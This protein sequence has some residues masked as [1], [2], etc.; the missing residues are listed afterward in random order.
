MVSCRDGFGRLRQD[1]VR[2]SIILAMLMTAYALPATGAQE[3]EAA[4]YDH[5]MSM[6]ER[7]PEAAFDEAIAWRDLGGGAPARHCAAAALLLLGY[8]QESATRFEELAQDPLLD[9]A[10]KP[11]ILCQAAEGWLGEGNTERAY[12]ALTS[13][14]KLQD[15]NPDLWLDRGIVLAEMGL[16]DEAVDDLSRA[17]VLDPGDPAGWLLRGSAYRLMEDYDAADT[18]IAEALRL[19]PS[20]LGAYL[21]RGNLHR[22]QGNDEAARKDWMI[23]IQRDPGSDLAETAR[24]NLERMDV[25]ST[26]P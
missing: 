3:S 1:M 23:I 8:F 7:N 19:D 2:T 15:S 22:L 6:I 14:I 9:P 17:I 18:D 21:E 20:D 24:R 13:G 26:D 25:G 10:L 5:C 16:L 11:M 12:A 4:K